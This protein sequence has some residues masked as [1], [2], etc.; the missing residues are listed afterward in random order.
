MASGN[1]ITGASYLI[2]GA[3]LLLKPQFRLFLI[4]PLMI[5]I[6]IF[7]ALT[8]LMYNYFD[9]AV[10]SVVALIP[11]W[12]WLSGIKQT[13]ALFISIISAFI[14]IVLYGYCFSII[15][16]IIAAPFYGFLAERVEVYLT[17]KAPPPES[18]LSMII[19]TLGRELV[20]LWYFIS[21]G[22][23]ITIGAFVLSF[24]PLAQFFVPVLLF[25]WAAWSM[26]IQYCD[27]CADN[28]QLQFTYFREGLAEKRFS[29]WG[30][31]SMVVLGSMI[32][33]LNIF[34][35]PAAVIG[36]TMLWI[37]EKPTARL[38]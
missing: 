10:A 30:F 34:V 18:V 33:L 6:V 22:I 38:I 16:N 11:D 25:L 35:L 9:D 4:V 2:D 14:G 5:N 31:G 7:I 13:L 1:L 21:R 8:S 17:G 23:L 29:A 37:N 36:G 19:R 26:A 12:D 15:T 28:H 24:I 32:P 27:Y 20:K 3:K